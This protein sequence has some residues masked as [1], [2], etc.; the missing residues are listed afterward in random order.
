MLGVLL[1][2]GCFSPSDAM[3]RLDAAPDVIV[4]DLLSCDETM[5]LWLRFDT[6]AE[7]LNDVCGG[8]VMPQKRD[9][10]SSIQFSELGVS[11][12]AWR[13]QASA[14]EKDF[15]FMPAAAAS[16]GCDKT[17]TMGMRFRVE[18]FALETTG[19][20][21]NM[22]FF[23]L[24]NLNDGFMIEG[25]QSGF[26]SENIWLYLDR[27]APVPDTNAT[28]NDFKIRKDVWTDVIVV[29][30]AAAK[31]WKLYVNGT[32]AG[33]TLSDIVCVLPNANKDAFLFDS[34]LGGTSGDASWSLLADEFF[35]LENTAWEL[36][37]V[38]SRSS[39]L[40]L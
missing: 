8:S 18:S 25:L 17:F 26:I 15:I 23:K 39:D 22:E 11:G 19:N 6:E 32:Q 7:G 27:V 36:E 33:S 40:P 38:T 5:K 24:G 9:S 28:F 29:H 2:G 35:W 3:S 31:T 37:Q 16:F 1:L 34:F 10:D 21:G 13:L 20:L 12:N 14:G 4:D 30:D